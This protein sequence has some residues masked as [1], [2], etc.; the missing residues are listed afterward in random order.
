[1]MKIER[2]QLLAKLNAV[3]GIVC[4]VKPKDEESAG[5]LIA[6]FSILQELVSNVGNM[7]CSETSVE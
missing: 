5:H 3:T 4:S 1:M 7:Q 2:E 6:A